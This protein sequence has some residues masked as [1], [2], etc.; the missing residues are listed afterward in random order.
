MKIEKI[1]LEVE[2]VERTTNE[3]DKHNRVIR[4]TTEFW[5]PKEKQGF[6]IGF[7]LKK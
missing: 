1:E 3:F 4:H 2:K 7:K 6:Q 5:Y